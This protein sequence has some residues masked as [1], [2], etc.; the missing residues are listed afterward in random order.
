MSFSTGVPHSK[1]DGNPCVCVC[2]NT[3]LSLPHWQ[4]HQPSRKSWGA[5]KTRNNVRAVAQWEVVRR[6]AV[7][8]E[9][10]NTPG[11]NQVK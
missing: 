11:Q 7:D 1:N 10:V 8:V 4:E 6:S 5:A 3:S 2:V 9:D